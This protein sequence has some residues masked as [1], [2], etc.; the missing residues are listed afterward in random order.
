MRKLG[1]ILGLI[2]G[3]LLGLL[4]APRKGKEFRESIGKE[5][6]EGGIGFE[7]LK[8]EMQKMGA[9]VVQ[10]AKEV[11][12]LPEVKQAIS[13]G[14][15][16]ARAYFKDMTEMGKEEAAKIAE[17]AKERVGEVMGLEDKWE[18]DDEVQ[19]QH[20]KIEAKNTRRSRENTRKSR[21]KRGKKK[22]K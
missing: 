7:T 22:K 4:F 17:T 1:T 2:F 16:R 18:S 10:L 5:M 20:R 8:K 3:T 13:S 9:E 21:E 14:K 6:K 11:R 12:E 15:K 19:F